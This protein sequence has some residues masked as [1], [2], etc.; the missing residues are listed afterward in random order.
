[1]LTDTARFLRERDGHEA[2]VTYVEQ[3]FD[4]IQRVALATGWLLVCGPALQI[5]GNGLYKR[6]VYGWFPLSHWI[7]P[8]LFAVIVPL[9]FHTDLL[10]MSGLTTV[11]MIVV[12][13]W[14]SVSPQA[15]QVSAE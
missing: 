13:A 3:L 5:I 7:A 4:L 9:A 2:R 6:I 8:G 10:I 15:G 12:A 1:M 14:E 11:V